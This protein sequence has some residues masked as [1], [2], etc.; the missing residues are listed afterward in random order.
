MNTHLVEKLKRAIGGRIFA[1]VYDGGR[2]QM[3]CLGDQEEVRHR[4]NQMAC[5]IGGTAMQTLQAC[6]ASA[7]HTRSAPPGSWFDHHNGNVPVG[8]PESLFELASQGPSE[9]A[10]NMGF[11]V[12]NKHWPQGMEE[13]LSG[14]KAMV[15]GMSELGN[16]FY[17]FELKPMVQVGMSN[18]TSTVRRAQEG[19]K[20]AKRAGYVP[21]KEDDLLQFMKTLMSARC[22]HFLHEVN[23]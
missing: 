21:Y 2:L 17:F 8:T 22:L 5:L 6:F 15:K 3:V 4:Y 11:L 12:A 9:C 20:A 1:T 7:G 18:D 23:L 16:V 14:A 10:E 19:I 13:N